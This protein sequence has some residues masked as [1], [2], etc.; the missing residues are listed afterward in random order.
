[1][2]DIIE[3]IE[4]SAVQLEIVEIGSGRLEVA[5]EGST[6]IEVIESTV[7]STDANILVVESLSDNTIIDIPGESASTIDAIVTNN[8][9]EI[10]ENQ[11]LIHTSSFITNVTQSITNITQS[12][13]GDNDLTN[14]IGDANITGQL[15]VSNTIFT[16]VISA[17]ISRLTSDGINNILIINS[18]SNSP[19]TVNS[20][21]LIIF[22]E[23]T[24]TPTA[25]EGGFLYSGSDFFIGLV[26][27]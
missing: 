20:E 9:I 8:I 16:D 23:F 27:S 21:G 24:Y 12:F 3:I 13:S 4:E 5:D 11:V 6:F 19:I 22:D 15:T 1:M 14:Y 25:I 10:T 7:D 26:D 17:S 2:A 18:G